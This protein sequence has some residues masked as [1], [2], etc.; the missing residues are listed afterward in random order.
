MAYCIFLLAK[1]KN[2][3][4]RFFTSLSIGLVNGA[5]SCLSF[6]MSHNADLIGDKGIWFAIGSINGIVA[7]GNLTN[8]IKMKK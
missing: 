5:A 8:F 2:I 3:M 1:N 4:S 6:L 7:I